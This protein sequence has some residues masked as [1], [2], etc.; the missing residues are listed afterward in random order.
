MRAKLLELVQREPQKYE[1]ARAA[2]R[3]GGGGTP[4]SRR[5]AA[6]SG[7]AKVPTDGELRLYMRRALM[8]GV[9]TKAHDAADAVLLP[10]IPAD[11]GSE[12]DELDELSIAPGMDSP[13]AAFAPVAV[14]SGS[15]AERQSSGTPLLL[16][17]FDFGLMARPTTASPDVEVMA[18]LMQRSRQ[19][20][21]GSGAGPA[22]MADRDPLEAPGG[23]ASCKMG[24][25]NG[26][27]AKLV[28]TRHVDAPSMGGGHTVYRIKVVEQDGTSWV[29]E[30]R[31][32]DFEA[33][34][35]ILERCNFESALPPM[36]PP[37]FFRKFASE[38]IAERSAAFQLLLDRC[39]EL[40]PEESG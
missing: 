26:C 14:A 23:G 4:S 5:R 18:L 29:A 19:A 13:T 16:A 28:G 8:Y 32:T 27:S 30:R 22:A 39:R 24:V 9:I 15:A 7:D 37:R 12:D 40:G 21:S 38:T 31:F 10:G 36:P 35:A 3:S 33:L 2:M 17:D 34:H 20:G 1:Q 25:W 6:K 11:G